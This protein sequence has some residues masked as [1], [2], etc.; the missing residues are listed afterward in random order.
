MPLS[1][2]KVELSK[3]HK[4]FLSVEY[5]HNKCPQVKINGKVINVGDCV[6]VRPDDVRTPLYVFKIV[7]LFQDNSLQTDNTN[8]SQN[9]LAHVQVCPTTHFCKKSF[10]AL[11]KVVDF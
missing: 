7:S 11:T 8:Q 1:V 2:S 5:F 3:E 9:K 10:R 6:L 4:L